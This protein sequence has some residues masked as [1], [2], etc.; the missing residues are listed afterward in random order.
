MKKSF[1]FFLLLASTLSA[2]ADER[3]EALV[4]GRQLQVNTTDGKTY[5]YIVSPLDN[6][7]I[8]R[9]T[10]EIVI[11]TDSFLLSDIKSM[12]Y[13]TMQHF[14]LNEDSV[15][16]G[17][18]YCVDHGLMAFRRTFN[19]GKWNSLTI[20]FSMTG[21]QVLETF[22]SDARL[23]VVDGLR[24]GD[25][26]DLDFST[27]Q[28]NTNEE[29]ITAGEHYLLMPTREPDIAA[30]EQL[31]T[32]WKAEPV[33]GPLYLVPVIS[34]KSGNSKPNVR[35]FYA[36]NSQQHINI[37]GSYFNLDGTYKVGTVVKNKKLAPGMY[38]FDD[39]GHFC[40]NTDSTAI[41]AF[42][43]WYKN[44][45]TTETDLHVYI[46]GVEDGGDVP[47]GIADVMRSTMKPVSY[48]V[49]DLQGRRVGSTDHMESLPKGLYIIRGRKQ[50]VE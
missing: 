45:S 22:G 13:R 35:H 36:N 25:A 19:L 18:N 16:F 2:P 10:G 27:V 3:V 44:L 43:S 20:P 29:V 21:R 48:I 12:R 49:Y 6:P 32:N 50:I 26:I 23:A 14:V 37:N 31:P 46:D 7:V 8:Y 33:E 38:T 34:L 28:L 1:V 4:R 5:H 9:L 47:T 42:R 39:D 30:G 15:T 17:G 11:Q 41:Q 24:G 40:Y